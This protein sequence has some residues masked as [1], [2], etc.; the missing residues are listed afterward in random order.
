MQFDFLE[1]QQ[2]DHIDAWLFVELNHRV[3]LIEHE[4]DSDTHWT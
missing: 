4:E 1:E 3:E 2:A